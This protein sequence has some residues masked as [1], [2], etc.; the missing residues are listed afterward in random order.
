MNDCMCL[1]EDG[2]PLSPELKLVTI[3]LEKTPRL[4]IYNS[5]LTAQNCK[6][7]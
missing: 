6:E 2:T 1:L 4:E 3:S 5:K 7:Q